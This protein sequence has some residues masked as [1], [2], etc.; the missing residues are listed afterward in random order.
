MCQDIDHAKE[1]ELKQTNQ[2][3]SNSRKSSDSIER[4]CVECGQELIGKDIYIIK[5]LYIISTLK[6]SSKLKKLYYIYRWLYRCNFQKSDGSFGGLFRCNFQK[7]VRSFGK[8]NSSNISCFLVLCRYWLG[9][10]SVHYIL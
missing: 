7:S 6:T 1:M 10:Q 4:G 2:K 5:P 8:T 9:H 3:E